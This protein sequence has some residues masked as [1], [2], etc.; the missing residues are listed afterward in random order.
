MTTNVI[1]SSCNV[2]LVQVVSV[3]NYKEMCQHR[4]NMLSFCIL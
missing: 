4:A 2:R 1:P 3:Q